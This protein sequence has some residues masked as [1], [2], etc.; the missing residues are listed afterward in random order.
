MYVYR[1]DSN[2]VLWAPIIVC[3][4]VFHA[5]LPQSLHIL[6]CEYVFPCWTPTEPVGLYVR[7]SFPLIFVKPNLANLVYLIIIDCIDSIT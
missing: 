1:M 6:L 5:G 2:G 7:M 3:E 4:C